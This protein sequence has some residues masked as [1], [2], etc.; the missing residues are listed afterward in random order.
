M[1]NQNYNEK[2]KLKKMQRIM[3]YVEQIF[4]ESIEEENIFST[5]FLNQ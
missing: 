2:K 1:E 3:S 4:L 5:G